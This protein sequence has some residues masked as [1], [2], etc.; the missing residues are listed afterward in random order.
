MEAWVLGGRRSLIA[1][2]EGACDEFEKD[3]SKSIARIENDKHELCEVQ[4]KHWKDAAGYTQFLERENRVLRE[5]LSDARRKLEQSSPTSHKHA[6]PSR[7]PLAGISPNQVAGRWIAGGRPGPSAHQSSPVTEEKDW[8]REC[9]K[10]AHKYNILND[11]YEKLAQKAREFRAD[12]E[13]WLKYA[14]VLEKKV[15]R[16]EKKR[17]EKETTTISK[18]C[19]APADAID[20]AIDCREAS[21]ASFASDT[22]FGPGAVDTDHRDDVADLRPRRAAPMPETDV[23]ST[24][25]IQEFDDLPP[26]PRNVGE[27]QFVK[28]KEEPSSDG[29]VVVSERNLR[30]RKCT[31]HEKDMPPPPSRKIK[32]EPHA[33]SDPVV[34][35]ETAGFSPHESID[36]DND[37]L[38]VPT[39]RKQRPLW[40]RTLR[41]DEDVTPGSHTS[42]VSR[43][44]FPK[45]VIDTP[46]ITPM[47]GREITGRSVALEQPRSKMA[48]TSRDG[49]WALKAGVADLAEDR[50]EAFD[51]PGPL[52]AS[53]ASRISPSTTGNRLQT[54]LNQLTPQ[55]EVAQLK[56][57][58]GDVHSTRPGFEAMESPLEARQL[59]GGSSKQTP[60][61][62]RE[63]PLA[64]LKVSDF[65]VN[66]KFN[67]GYKFA[68]DEVVRNRGDRAELDG[69]TDYNCCGRHYRVLAESEL[70]ATG[71]VVLSR[72][73]DIKMMEDYLGSVVHKLGDMTQ[74]EQKEVWIKAKSQSF[75]NRLGKHRHR[76]TRQA[77][78]PGYWNPDFP[79]TQEVEEN[80]EESARRERK[81]IEERWREA[82]KM[83]GTGKWLFRDE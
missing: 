61:R 53:N 41:G 52:V 7:L 1:A 6:Y 79:T 33:S 78:P 58:R 3:L 80:R 22:D 5:E 23:S 4:I 73:E 67:N 57:A 83:G 36:L 8:E 35:G 40:M 34:T 17:Q 76:F 59:N 25:D 38:E 29:P 63:T 68:F 20:D 42:N 24:H 39:P 21:A 45:S 32:S 28:I 43:S 55:S 49:E 72:E 77:S 27:E 16:L 82:M 15:Q 70:N 66:P 54:L 44:L 64:Q 46:P 65:K 74:E 26:M 2:L 12:K 10:I 62:L 14:E 11:R 13:G 75:A 19:A 47:L 30:K 71:L 31:D 81:Q 69:C 60:R 50:P 56:P 51:L 37:Q 9:M 18:A 48:R